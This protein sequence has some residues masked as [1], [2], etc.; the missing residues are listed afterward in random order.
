MPAVL[1]PPISTILRRLSEKAVSKD[2]RPEGRISA[3]RSLCVLR[4]G[5]SG[6]LR[7]LRTELRKDLPRKTV[8]ER[9][10]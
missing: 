7:M 8:N 5:P 2:A 3:A 9:S 10:F 4:D 6:L 1:Q